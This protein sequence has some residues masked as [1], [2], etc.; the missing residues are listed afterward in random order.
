MDWGEGYNTPPDSSTG[1]DEDSETETS[2]SEV[3]PPPPTLTQ[4]SHTP[5]VPSVERIMPMHVT[6]KPDSKWTFVPDGTLDVVIPMEMWDRVMGHLVRQNDTYMFRNMYPIAVAY[7]FVE[8]LKQAALS[9][10][11]IVYSELSRQ[12]EA[13]DDPTTM[14]LRVYEKTTRT[15]VIPTFNETLTPVT[16]RKVAL[17]EHLHVTEEGRKDTIEVLVYEMKLD[18][19]IANDGHKRW[20][21]IKLLWRPNGDILVEVFESYFYRSLRSQQIIETRG[22]ISQLLAVTIFQRYIPYTLVFSDLPG[23]P[24]DAFRV[25]FHKWVDHEITKDGEFTGYEREFAQGDGILHAYDTFVN[26]TESRIEY[27]TRLRIPL[28]EIANH[29]PYRPCRKSMFE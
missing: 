15:H 19:F 6:G 27:T 2:S 24:V 8:M 12:V 26:I 14:S 5:W 18:T 20:G 17:D 11:G 16:V 23:K 4:V 28:S 9:T 10:G 7:G 21:T 1:S 22:M 3:S 13:V 29:N 25:F